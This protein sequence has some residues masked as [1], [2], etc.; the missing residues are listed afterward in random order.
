MTKFNDLIQNSEVPI[1]VDF[2]A[3]WC[4]PCKML[5]PILQ[6]FAS[7]VRGKIK[8][9]KVDIDKNPMA[10]QKYSIKG[11]PTLILFHRG[12]ILWQQFGLVPKH[13][14]HKMILAHV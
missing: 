11:V 8:V 6:E 1:L 14:L 10:A 2:T 4:G 7:E 5:A 9:I 3:A 13:E 12:N